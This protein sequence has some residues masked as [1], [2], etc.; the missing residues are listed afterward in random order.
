M[1]RQPTQRCTFSLG[2]AAVSVIDWHDL[3]VSERPLALVLSH[4]TGAYASEIIAWIALASTTNTTL[5]LLTAASRLLYA[6]SLH[7]S[8][9]ATLSSIGRRT[10]APQIAAI[11]ACLG[12]IPLA[13]TEQLGL[14]A[15]ITDFAV[16]AVFIAVNLSVLRLRMIYPD[17]PRPIHAGPDIAGWPIAPIIGLAATGVML[18]FLDRDAWL[19]GGALLGAGVAVWFSFGKAHARSRSA[20]G[21]A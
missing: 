15:A 4:A 13:F 14:V 8:L 10:N 3:A 12:A 11:V 6:M 5:L 19:V 18:V 1:L 9:P 20:V 2:V 21:D 16:Y 7:G 17:L